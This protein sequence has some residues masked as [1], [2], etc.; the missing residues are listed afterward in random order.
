MLSGGETPEDR[1]GL[2]SCF[3]QGYWV[4]IEWDADTEN[5]PNGGHCQTFSDP[6]YRL[7]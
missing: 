4:E 1:L 3:K 6:R 7:I 2:C 5:V